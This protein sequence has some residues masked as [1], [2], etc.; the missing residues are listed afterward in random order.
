VP[1]ATAR[2][3]PLNT[4]RPIEVTVDAAGLPLAVMTAAGWRRVERVQDVWRIDEGWWRD[5][6]SRRYFALALDGGALR[7]VFQDLVTREWHAQR[8]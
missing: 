5:T 7:V 2:I 1:E 4:P 6:L 3:A 8:Y